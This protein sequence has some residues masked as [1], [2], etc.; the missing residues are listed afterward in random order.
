MFQSGSEMSENPVRASE[1][2][3]VQSMSERV[4]GSS[5]GLRESECPVRV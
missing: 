4:R 3:R 1:G 5:Q 2:Q